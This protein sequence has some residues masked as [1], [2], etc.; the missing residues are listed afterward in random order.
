MLVVRDEAR[1]IRLAL[2]WNV[3]EFELSKDQYAAVTVRY[4][5]SNN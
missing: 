2:R 4:S 1:V 3:A 5:S